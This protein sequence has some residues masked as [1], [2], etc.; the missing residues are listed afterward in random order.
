[1]IAFLDDDKKKK[2]KRLEGVSIYNT[3]D[4]LEDLLRANN[5][6]HVIISIQNISQARKQAIIEKVLNHDAKILNVPP[7]N[8]WI[9]GELSFKQIKKVRI[10]DLLERDPIKLDTESIR[11]ALSGKVIL[12]TGGAGSIGSELVRQIIP[13]KPSRSSSWTRLSPRCMTWRLRYLNISV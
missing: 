8:S 4:D 7:V 10:E 9:N 11:K 2:G 6:A 3:E 13:F 12:I 5:V 1:V